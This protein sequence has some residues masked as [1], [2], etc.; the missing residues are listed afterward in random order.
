M[1]G[2]VFTVS[3]CAGGVFFGG[4]PTIGDDTERVS[5]FTLSSSCDR[6]NVRGRGAF[7][8]G[9]VGFSGSYEYFFRITRQYG[10]E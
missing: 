3:R 6:R 2:N 1:N 7:V 9:R 5:A 4:C 8:F 10:D